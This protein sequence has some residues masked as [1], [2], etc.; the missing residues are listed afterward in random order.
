MAFHG[1]ACGYKKHS[2]PR[3][4]YKKLIFYVCCQ[5]RIRYLIERQWIKDMSGSIFF[6]TSHPMSW[7]AQSTVLLP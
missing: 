7:K 4:S 3:S 2:W 1:K 5:I 6:D